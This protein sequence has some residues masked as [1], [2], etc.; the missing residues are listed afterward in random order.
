MRRKSRKKPNNVLL[1]ATSAV[2]PN[3]LPIIVEN[4]LL[5]FANMTAVPYVNLTDQNITIKCGNIL[6]YA[7]ELYPEELLEDKKF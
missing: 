3:K 1:V 6:T 4:A 2:Q 5:H 7:E